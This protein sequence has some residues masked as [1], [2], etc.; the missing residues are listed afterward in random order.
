MKLTEVFEMKEPNKISYMATIED[1]VIYQKPW[2]FVKTFDRVPK[3]D[4]ILSHSCVENEKDLAYM[5]PG[6]IVGGDQR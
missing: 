2:S 6:A 1:P 5:K 3:G 4:R